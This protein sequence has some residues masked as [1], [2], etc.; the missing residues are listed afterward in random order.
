MSARAATAAVAFL[1][2]ALAP[3]LAEQTRAPLQTAA[4]AYKVETFARGLEHPWGLAFLPGGRLLV[5]ER[6]GRLRLIGKDGRLSRP[7]GGVPAVQVGGQGGLLDVA[8]DPGFAASRLVYISY[9]EP[10]RGGGSATT[11]AR[12]RLAEGGGARLADVEVIFRQQ[13]AG[14]SGIH[15]GSRLVFARDGNLFITLG[16]RGER[17]KAQDLTTHYGKVVRIRPDGTV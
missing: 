17:A 14:Q 1:T 15:F 13:P 5:T 3:A 10:R 8:L 4:Q 9:A 11:V 12:G 16:E 7:I 6:P 2:V